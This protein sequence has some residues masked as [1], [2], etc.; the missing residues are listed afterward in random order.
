M[1]SFPVRLSLAASIVICSLLLMTATSALGADPTC[2]PSDPPMGCA[3][4]TLSPTG[5]TGD[6]Y[7][8]DVLIATAQPVAALSVPAGT[9]KVVI[10][11]IQSPEAGFGSLFTYADTTVNVN[12]AAGQS[13]SYAAKPTKTYIRGTLA[14]T[15]DIRNATGAVVGCQVSIDGV[16]QPDVLNPA[17]K[18]SYILDPGTHTVLVALVGDQAWQF[19]P[20]SK[21]QTVRIRASATPT[22]VSVRF[23]KKGLATLTLSVAGTVADFYV[24]GA[25]VATQVAT[26][27]IY[28]T[29]GTAHKFEARNV[30]D[31]AANG[32]YRWK[33]V[34]LTTSLFA[35]SKKTIK[36]NLQKEFLRGF[37]EITCKLT[38]LPAGAAAQCQP[39][40]DGTAVAPI[41]AGQKATYNLLRGTHEV[42]VDAAPADQ[43]A[44]TPALKIVTITAGRTEKYTA[45]IAVET[46][47]DA[48]Q[49]HT[50]DLPDDIAGKQ[51]RIMYVVPSDG[52]DRSLDTNGGL[53]ETVA[54]MQGWFFGQTPGRT[55]Q[56]DTYYGVHDIGFYRM[57]RTNYELGYAPDLVG[58]ILKELS[59]AGLTK[60]NKIL[61]I[62]YDGASYF[63]CGG[64]TRPGS[65]AAIYLGGLPN[66]P[67]PCDMTAPSDPAQL[68]Y[69]DYLMVR[70]LLRAMGF[71][72]NCATH[73]FLG[74]VSDNNTDVMWQGDGYWYPS[75]LDVNH[76]DYYMANIP[77]CFDLS[78]SGWLTP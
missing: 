3:V 70:N 52:A 46:I 32:N 11:N 69:L 45:T 60:S 47:V 13:K 28:V 24:D 58:E 27:D 74:Y 76:D 26:F 51:I 77:G 44:A 61:A 68:S 78:T 75:T 25:L 50:N 73:H 19:S 23:D 56:M 4:V 35:N 29:P 2:T 57:S 9:Q 62:Y 64:A 14:L 53:N 48:T 10:R 41:E 59:K 63:T 33:D 49:R 21:T 71:V 55:L 15:C 54:R 30:T 5:L 38:G 39:S 22:T 67:T 16:V 7:F 18:G 6:F 1:R 17:G 8:N 37:L 20:D 31:P 65:G 36:F 43:W 42:T 40:I 12:V 34:S 72:P 66:W